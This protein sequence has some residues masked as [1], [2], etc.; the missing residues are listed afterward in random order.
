VRVGHVAIALE[1]YDEASR[2]PKYG[3]VETTIH[4]YVVSLAHPAL[5]LT[6]MGYPE[7]C[8]LLHSALAEANDARAVAHLYCRTRFSRLDADAG[9]RTGMDFEAQQTPGSVPLRVVHSC[10]HV[11]TYHVPN[12]MSGVGRWRMVVRLSSVACPN[13]VKENG[14]TLPSLVMATTLAA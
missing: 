4:P 6:L 3:R 12:W 11:E 7:F 14:S 5:P 10:H 1:G 13:C 8:E 2:R 9:G